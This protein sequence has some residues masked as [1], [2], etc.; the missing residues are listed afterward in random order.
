MNYIFFRT[1]KEIIKEGI[2][3]D[4]YLAWKT[5]KLIFKDKKLEKVIQSINKAYDCEIVLANKENSNC[6]FTDT[7][8]NLSPKVL[9]YKP[10][11]VPQLS[12]M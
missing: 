11:T 9:K 5:K 10:A 12:L 6:R 1:R 7:F 3:D 8:D 4:N 2:E